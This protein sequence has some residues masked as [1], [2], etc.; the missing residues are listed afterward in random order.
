[1]TSSPTT[2]ERWMHLLS[3]LAERPSPETPPTVVDR[4]PHRSLRASHATTWSEALAEARHHGVAALL[5][6]RLREHRLLPAGDARHAWERRP[7]Q[8]SIATL[9]RHAHAAA[10]GR[11][12]A[13]AGVPF[14]PF[15]GFA[16][17]HTVYP[18]PVTRPM[19]DVD[20]WVDVREVATAVDVMKARGFT[21][22]EASDRPWEWQAM[23]DGQLVA[24]HPGG[25]PVELHVGVFPGT[26]MQVAARIDRHAVR[27]R[28]VPTTFVSVPGWTLDTN[29]HLI[30]IAL[31]TVITHQGERAPVRGMVDMALLCRFGAG[32]DASVV[33]R[34]ATEWNIA[35]VVAHACSEAAVWLDV[36][37]L[38][39]V[40]E[41]LR[42]GARRMAGPRLPS[43]VVHE[44]NTA[45]ARPRS[46]LARTT[47]LLAAVDRPSD[48][49]R[50]LARTIWPSKAWLDARYSADATQ[51]QGRR[52][53]YL[54]GLIRDRL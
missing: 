26:W 11:D 33:V 52:L 47:Y 50:L 12:L 19:G 16:L 49:A 42:P 17:A 5:L 1:M 39:A 54:A 44:G 23:H 10:L 8:R 2:P 45:K 37:E 40:A 43:L 6:H 18:D 32:F 9:R 7:T 48:A 22:T 13:A 24:Q 36:P 30:Q 51:P 20:L 15:K 34:R 14:V 28:L 41:A 35:R 46:R 4:A 27:E 53:R 25:F 38:A 21:F 29:D 3:A 31:H